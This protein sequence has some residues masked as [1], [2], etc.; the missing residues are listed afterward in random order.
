VAAQGAIWRYVMRT[1]LTP[2]EELQAFSE[3]FGRR[4]K[5]AYMTG[6]EILEKKAEAKGKVEGKADVLLRLLEIKFGRLPKATVKR[7]RSATT[8]ELDRWVERVLTASS[9]DEVLKT[10]NG[11]AAARG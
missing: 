7:V 1:T 11:R 2:L 10:R 9:L 5:E 6:A 4:G 8:A 3:R